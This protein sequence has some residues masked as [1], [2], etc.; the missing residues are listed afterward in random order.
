MEIESLK[1]IEEIRN[2]IDIIKEHIITESEID[3]VLYDIYGN[4]VEKIYVIILAGV[5]EGELY[6]KQ[7][8]LFDEIVLIRKILYWKYIEEKQ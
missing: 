5:N 8:E 6:K 1:G 7:A 4:Y 2:T 3:T